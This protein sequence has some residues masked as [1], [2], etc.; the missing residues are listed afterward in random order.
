[1]SDPHE[2][3]RKWLSPPKTRA[4]FAEELGV[5]PQAVSNW[6]AKDTKHRTRPAANLRKKIE[7]ETGIPR[8]DWL[9]AEEREAAGLD[10]NT[11][12]GEA[13]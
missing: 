11:S 3:L 6:C 1:M 10:E 8:T 5:S 12:D 9:T 7:E 2:A 13:A 4:E